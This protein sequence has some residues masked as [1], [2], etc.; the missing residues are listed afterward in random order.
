MD[1]P[2][3]LYLVIWQEKKRGDWQTTRLAS[4]TT[5]AQAKRHTE[6]M[7]AAYPD[8][9]PHLVI[10]AD[11][12]RHPRAMERLNAMK[13]KTVIALLGDSNEQTRP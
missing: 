1:K 3:P 7:D 12:G 10:N 13:P 8:D 4:H 6:L 2:K 9:A 11:I 5:L